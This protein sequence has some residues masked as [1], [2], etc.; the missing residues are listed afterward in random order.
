[1][2]SSGLYSPAAEAVEYFNVKF[3]R[4]LKDDVPLYEEIPSTASDEAWEA[5]WN[6]SYLMVPKDKASQMVN[7]TWELTGNNKGNSL[8]SLDVFHQ[9]HCL[10]TIRKVAQ[11]KYY[12]DYRVPLKH[13]RHC[14]G[15][16][17]QALMCFGDITPI[18][19]R[20]SEELGELEQRDDVLHTCRDF[21]KIMDWAKKHRAE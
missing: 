10:D 15:T 3:H 2:G 7:S 1:M 8:L 18:V 16:I 19:W 17:R 21:G 12:P 5:L 14:T 13:I 6:V 4:G 9:L 20:W 11:P